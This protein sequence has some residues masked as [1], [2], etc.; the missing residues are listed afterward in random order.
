MSRHP[1]YI[2]E[3]I[4][5][6]ARGFLRNETQLIE[7][8]PGPYP[9]FQPLCRIAEGLASHGHSTNHYCL[10]YKT[11]ISELSTHPLSRALRRVIDRLPELIETRFRNW[12]WAYALTPDGLH[13]IRDRLRV[14]RESTYLPL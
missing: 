3:D 5:K 6:Y 2:L 13:E 1:Y 10:E 12:G 4:V 8:P 14:H 9:F 11:Q 7:P